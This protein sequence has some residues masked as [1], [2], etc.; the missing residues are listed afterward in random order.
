MP[1]LWLML[2][3]TERFKSKSHM[4]YEYADVRVLVCVVM[5]W[6]NLRVGSEERGEGGKVL[7][8]LKIR[9]GSHVVIRGILMH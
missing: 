2:R 7:I 3:V 4:L 8:V 5:M 9:Y 1:P 6:V